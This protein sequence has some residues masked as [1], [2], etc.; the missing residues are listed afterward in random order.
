MFT[1][2]QS[3][4]SVTQPL[5]SP[6]HKIIIQKVENVKLEIITNSSKPIPISSLFTSENLE[7]SDQN[8]QCHT[9]DSIFD[10]K[11]EDLPEIESENVANNN[12]AQNTHL[13]LLSAK[14][15][16][17]NFNAKIPL[18]MVRTLKVPK[19]KP[20]LLHRIHRVETNTVQRFMNVLL[21]VDLEVKCEVQTPSLEETND[22]KIVSDVVQHDLAP[23]F[24]GF[25]VDLAQKHYNIS[26]WGDVLSAA[27]KDDAIELHEKQADL[28][29]VAVQDS[30]QK[31]TTATSEN[32]QMDIDINE[33]PV[34]NK[35]LFTTSLKQFPSDEKASMLPPIKEQPF[36]IEKPL[37]N[38]KNSEKFLKTSQLVSSTPIS[39][40]CLPSTSKSLPTTSKNVKFS[41]VEPE[42]KKEVKEDWMEDILTVIGTSRIAQIDENL[43]DIPSLITGNFSLIETENVEFKLIIKHLLREL[44]VSSILDTVKFPSR[45]MLS[46]ISMFK[47]KFLFPMEIFSRKIH[48]AQNFDSK[49]MFFR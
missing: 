42:V 18:K 40:N 37:L 1:D 30:H 49:F 19:S 17:N 25:D 22:I 35:L 36:L 48:S 43:Q 7:L 6:E 14:I 27:V 32:S 21:P 10:S 9:N 46:E 31:F 47:G 45:N 3:S 2:S 13:K 12:S 24:S 38:N 41:E 29:P 44:G 20:N 28:I 33:S 26:L 34:S 23:S 8:A 15:P 4:P 11:P 5:K 16:E 39:S